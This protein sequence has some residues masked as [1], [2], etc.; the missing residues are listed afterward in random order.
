MLDV[1]IRIDSVRPVCPVCRAILLPALEILRK[2]MSDSVDRFRD[3][4]APYRIVTRL[5]AHLE[6]LFAL[7]LKGRIPEAMEVLSRH[8]IDHVTPDLDAYLAVL[9]ED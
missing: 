6:E 9:V 4:L 8:G 7:L 1:A 3:A 2:V 5:F